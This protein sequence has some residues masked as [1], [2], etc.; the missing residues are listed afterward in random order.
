MESPEL[1]IYQR[2]YTLVL[3][4]MFQVAV[5]QHCK[6]CDRGLRCNGDTHFI[7]F[8]RRYG[9]YSDFLKRVAKEYVTKEAVLEKVPEVM[10]EF[11][12]LTLANMKGKIEEMKLYEKCF[13]CPSRFEGEVEYMVTGNVCY[14]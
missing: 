12:T 8:R 3:K 7:D 5:V 9:E 2:A 11:Q 10:T 4:E 14:T 13:C 1:L 6:R